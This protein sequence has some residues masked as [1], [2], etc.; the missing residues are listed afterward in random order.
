MSRL[1]KS[2]G[3]YCRISSLLQG[4]FAK[5]TYDFKGPTNRSHPIIFILVVCLI[6]QKVHVCV[7]V[8]V[9]EV[10]DPM[11]GDTHI[12]FCAY[13]G[14]LADMQGSFANIQGSFANIQGSFVDIQGSFAK[15]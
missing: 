11:H 3:L 15:I 6:W 7:C 10:S 4:S 9:R 14:S 13:M 1:L 12:P 2:I 5:E 8:C